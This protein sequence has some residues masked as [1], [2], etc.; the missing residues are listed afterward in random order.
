[1][2]GLCTR[3]LYP[4]YRSKISPE[5][6]GV[7]DYIEELPEQ[8]V[9]LLSVVFDPASKPGCLTVAFSRH[10]GKTR[11]GTAMTL[12]VSGTGMAD[13]LVTKIAGRPATA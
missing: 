11:G 12:W 1:M 10:T 13:E 3:L 2:I 4:V 7:Y 9:F 5:V 6:R 8:S